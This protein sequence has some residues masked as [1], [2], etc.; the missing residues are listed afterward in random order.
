VSGTAAALGLFSQLTA[1]I[2]VACGVD[3]GTTACV[4]QAT[5]TGGP[6][7]SQY[8]ACAADMSG[9]ADGG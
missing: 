1:C 6:C 2:A 3:G 5:E 8:N 4:L 7:A 9:A